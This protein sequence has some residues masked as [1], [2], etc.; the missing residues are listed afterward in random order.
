MTIAIPTGVQIFCWIATMWMGRARLTVPM[1]F[2]LG[3]I[4]TFVNGGITGVMLASVPFDKQAHDTFFVVAHLHYVLLGGG[5]M[6]LFGAFYY[7]FPKITG[8]MLGDTLGKWHAWLFVI[9]VNVTFFPMHLLGLDGMPRRIYTYLAPTGWGTLNMIAT[10]GAFTIA[11]AVLLFIINALRSW[12]GGAIAGENP[13]D[14]SGL[15]WAATSPP[16]SYNFAFPIV[17]RDRHPLWAARAEHEIITGLRRD[18]REGL[19]TTIV[20]ARIDSRHVDPEPSFWPAY[21]A[22]CMAVIFIGSI[23]SPYFVL[24][25]IVLSFVGLLGW[26]LESSRRLDIEIVALPDGTLVEG[27]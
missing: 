7:W 3:F 8:R 13:W 21:L 6:P 25:G 15:E 2:L 24:G 20:D 12:R 18:R 1:L 16:A 22:G 17:V 5:I 11:T 19:L 23:F 9:G 14:S 4:F 27:R 10:I 26:A